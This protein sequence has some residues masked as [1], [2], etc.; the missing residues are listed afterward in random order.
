MS[1][2]YTGCSACGK[3]ER[4]WGQDWIPAY[5]DNQDILCDTPKSGEVYVFTHYI[6]LQTEL[7]KFI[8]VCSHT[9]VREVSTT[10][11]FTGYPPSWLFTLHLHPTHQSLD[12]LYPLQFLLIICNPFYSCLKPFPLI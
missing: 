12:R 8:M 10:T 7:N 1:S 6:Q 9:E 3:F 2:V 11:C 5:N 4:G